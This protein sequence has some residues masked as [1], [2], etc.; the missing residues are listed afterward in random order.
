V[1]V[2]AIAWATVAVQQSLAAGSAAY[3]WSH[4]GYVLAVAAGVVVATWETRAA[5]TV[6]DFSPATVG[7]RARLLLALGCLAAMV[8]CV[9]AVGLADGGVLSAALVGVV[10]GGLTAA[11]GGG[12]TLLAT[13]G[14]DY[15]SRK[16]DERT[17]DDW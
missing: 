6:A 9:A 11:A 4:L 5:L 3:G 16:V 1:V 14:A 8:A 2:G 15:A 17:R 7:R 13:A 12:A 10:A